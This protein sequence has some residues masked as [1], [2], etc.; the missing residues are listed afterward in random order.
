M[1]AK[2]KCQEET[3]ECHTHVVSQPLL[4]SFSSGSPDFDRT[5]DC[6]QSNFSQGDIQISRYP[7]API[8][9][10]AN[11]KYLKSQFENL[12]RKFENQNYLKI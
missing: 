5:T 7:K 4:A 12:L 8:G 3:S 2:C 1:N 6:Q 10:L 11:E 9:L